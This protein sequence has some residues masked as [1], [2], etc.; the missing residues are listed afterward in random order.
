MPGVRHP[1]EHPSPGPEQPSRAGEGGF[2]ILQ[3]FEARDEQEEIEGSD[4]GGLGLLQ[5]KGEE[6]ERGHTPVAGARRPDHG[7]IRVDADPLGDF[8]CERGELIADAAADIQHPGR[9]AAP[10]G[11]QPGRTPSEQ[12]PPQ[13][14]AA[15]P[16]PPLREPIPNTRG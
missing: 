5:G 3:M 11:E 7:R 1:N 4:S 16:H 13:G 8:G 15:A 2:G 14:A 12:R 10:E 6:A 9:R